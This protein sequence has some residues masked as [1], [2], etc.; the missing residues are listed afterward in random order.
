MESSC[1]VRPSKEPTST[2]E[3]LLGSS[4]S[5]SRHQERE[6]YSGGSLG[7]KL[8]GINLAVHKYDASGNESI[9]EIS[10]GSPMME[11]R[12]ESTHKRLRSDT[13]TRYCYLTTVKI[14]AAKVDTTMTTMEKRTRKRKMK[15][16]ERGGSRLRSLSTIRMMWSKEADLFCL[17]CQ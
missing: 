4:Q 17:H 10:L 5:S 2:P 11:E 6:S 12:T 15:V 13:V 16:V 14:L 8:R 9:P 7:G 3:S 1:R